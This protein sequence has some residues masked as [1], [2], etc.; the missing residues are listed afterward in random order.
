LQYVF[1]ERRKAP[2][3]EQIANPEREAAG[4]WHLRTAM[5]CSTKNMA[6]RPALRSTTHQ[7]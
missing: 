5:L 1:E 3:L 6:L 4:I 2:R 7:F